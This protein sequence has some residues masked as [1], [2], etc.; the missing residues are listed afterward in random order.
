MSELVVEAPV[1]AVTVY[2][3]RA[4]VTRR[5][6]ITVPGGDQVVYVEPL[7]LLLEQD[8]VRV[9]GRGPATVLGVDVATR[10]HPQAPDETVAELKRAQRAAQDEIAALGDA[11]D[12][13]VQLETFLGQLAKRAGGSFARTLASGDQGAELGG[14]TESLAGR[15]SAVRATRRELTVQRREVEERLAAVDRRLA[16]LKEKRA[17]DRLTAAVSLALESEAE[18]EVEIELS[19]IVPAAGWTSSYDVRLTG[20]RLTLSWYGLITQYTGEDWP[21]CD[22]TLSTA[23]PTVTAKVPELDAWYLDRAHPHPPMPVA[24]PAAAPYR[25]TVT[26][27]SAFA[28]GLQRAD[29]ADLDATVE[30]GVTAATY[31]PPRPVA[32]PADGA[33]HRAT[34]AAIELDADLDYITAPVRSTDVH[35]RATVVNSS[36]HTLPA[37]KAA[38]FHE[39]D[40]VGSA[41]LPLWAAGEDVELAL[42]LDDRIR[43]ERKLVRRDATKATL[44]S[45][46]RRQVEY[47][48]TIE[49]H[50]PRTA[51]I[52][53]LDQFP[54][55]RDHEI[56]VK[57]LTADPEPAETTDLGVVT[58]KLDLA[59]DTETTV[60]LAF[61]VDTGKSVDLTGWRE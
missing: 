11:D 51:R 6:R 20:D 27:Q 23:R 24:A 16:A 47:E 13:Q 61:R 30:Q 52:T 9:S 28:E 40:F 55:A 14:F 8:S 3:D 42:G 38:V 58:W 17:P 54:V 36:V 5:G 35:L 32:V 22:L 46:R 18:V 12:V 43:V 34:I 1:V 10:Y 41:A 25:G 26:P 33:T 4:R 59:P 50:T 39:A 2:P 37:G 48:T 44:G 29:F 45:T 60:K 19:Y 49:N 53:V 7:P 57:R 21:E 56:T 15:L 31:T